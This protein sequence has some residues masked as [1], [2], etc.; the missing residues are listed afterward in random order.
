MDRHIRESSSIT[1][2]AAATTTTTQALFP[3]GLPFLCANSENNFRAVDH[4]WRRQ[5]SSSKAAA[6]SQAVPSPRTP[7]RRDSPCR[8]PAPHLTRS[9]DGKGR[10]GVARGAQRVTATGAG[11]AANCGAH[12][13]LRALCSN[14]AN[15]RCTC[16]MLDQ[17]PDIMHFFSTFT[18][19]PEQVIEVPKIL[20]DDVP[21]RMLFAIRNWRDSWWK[22][23]R[24]RGTHLRWFFSRRELQGIL[25][26]QGSTACG[27]EQIVDIPV[28]QGPRGRRGRRP[29]RF[30]PST[31]F[32]S[33]DR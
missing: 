24:T 25:S 17:L 3:Q 2:T 20:P 16:E 6:T 5:R 11:P 13:R 33:A 8:V 28:R 31:K 22:C 32:S 19:D 30:S 7:E 23:R 1:T 21:M 29:S 9:E 12:C 26:G 10:G 15:S 4:G 14:G 27:S 18:P